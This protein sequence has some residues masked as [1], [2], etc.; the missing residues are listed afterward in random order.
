LSNP[1]LPFDVH[2][3]KCVALKVYD[4]KFVARFTFVTF[5]YGEKPD[6]RYDPK[7]EEL[8]E[9]DQAL[10]NAAWNVLRCNLSQEITYTVP[11]ELWPR[12]M[13]YSKQLELTFGNEEIPVFLRANPHKVATLAYCFALFEG[14]E[15][16]ERHVQQAYGWLTECGVD[17]ELD[18]FT[19]EWKKEHRLSDQEYSELK[20]TIEAQIAAD[21]EEHGGELRDSELFKFFEHIAR[22][23]QAQMEEIAAA[24]NLSDPTVKRRAKEMKGLGLIQSSIKGYSLT[25]KGVRF[26]KRWLKD[27]RNDGELNEPN[28]PA[29]VGHK[30]F[31]DEKMPVTPETKINGII[32]ITIDSNTMLAVKDWCRAKR[33]ER[34][35]ISRLELTDFIKNDLKFE[36]PRRV[37]EKAM[38][39]GILQDSTKP[40][41]AVVV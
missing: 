2:L 13:Q 9:Q 23:G 11:L 12:I 21:M 19:Q 28:D 6:V 27:I 36:D 30:P 16:T 17:A 3:H 40:G 37:I 1:A 20:S 8:S 4:S 32:E 24:A 18:E 10:L 34:S 7:I 15:P 31:R 25:P 14:T 33:N 22:H 41:L 35:E 39:R 5:T 26:Y 29:F 38:E